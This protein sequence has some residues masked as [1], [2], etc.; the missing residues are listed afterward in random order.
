MLGYACRLSPA[1]GAL[2][3]SDCRLRL[4][5]VH[6][7]FVAAGVTGEADQGRRAVDD[8]SVAADAAIKQFDRFHRHATT[9]GAVAVVMLLA[10]PQSKQ[11]SQVRTRGRFRLV[12]HTEL[13]ASLLRRVFLKRKNVWL[14]NRLRFPEDG[15]LS[16]P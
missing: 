6:A 14:V 12:Y 13:T 1:Y 5:L 3:F 10:C 8:G 2:S 7:P 16:H 9:G 4:F 15:K 11:S